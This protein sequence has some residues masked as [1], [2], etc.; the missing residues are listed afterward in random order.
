MFWQNEPDYVKFEVI[1]DSLYI[2]EFLARRKM[3]ENGGIT[4]VKLLS[5][6]ETCENTQKKWN[7]LF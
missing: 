6:V 3:T 1:K 2:I 7:W 4:Q 5:T